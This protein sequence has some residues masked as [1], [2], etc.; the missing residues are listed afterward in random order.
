MVCIPRIWKIMGGSAADV[1]IHPT[2]ALADVL[3]NVSSGYV[4]IDAYASIAH[5]TMLLTGAH[6]YEQFGA[7]RQLAIKK[8]R[9]III[10]EGVWIA[11][12]CIIVGP[13]RIGK[14]SVVGAGSVITKDVPPF[15]VVVGNP[16]KI[17]KLIKARPVL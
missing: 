1:K 15:V 10:E 4:Q 11:S 5:N 17:I 12:G 8:N 14:H 2:A 6:D 7:A 13:C 9:N 3:I 16:A